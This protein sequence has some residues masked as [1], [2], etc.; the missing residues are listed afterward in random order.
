MKVRAQIETTGRDARWEFD[1]KKLFYKTDHI[2]EVCK[3]LADVAQV[4]LYQSA[5]YVFC[6]KNSNDYKLSMPV[7]V[8]I[9]Q[10]CFY[11]II[12]LMRILE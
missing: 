1:R 9:T 3:D 12:K 11:G 5:C 6:L 10:Y 7:I 8:Q 2:A 4:I